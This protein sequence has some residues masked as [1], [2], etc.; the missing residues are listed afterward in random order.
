MWIVA[1]TASLCLNRYLSQE[2]R[3]RFDRFA[4]TVLPDLIALMSNSAKVMATSGIVAIRFI[5][6][7]TYSHRLLPILTSSMTCKSNVT[8][9]CICEFMEIIFQL[10]PVNVLEKHLGLVQDSLRRGICDA[11]SDARVFAR[12]AFPLFA[13]KFPD[14]A[15]VMLQNLDAQKRK[16]VEK[17]MIAAGLAAGA[18]DAESVRSRSNSQTAIQNRVA[19]NPITKRPTKPVLGTTAIVSAAS[20]SRPPVTTLNDYNTVGRYIRQG[21]MAA[22]VDGRGRVPGRKTVSQS[23]PTSRE[24]SPSRLTFMSYGITGDGQQ[25]QQLPYNAAGYATRNGIIDRQ[26]TVDSS[27][28]QGLTSRI[29]R[30]QGASRETSPSRSATG[31]Y[32]TAA[33]PFQHQEHS[34]FNGRGA[35][36]MSY[37]GRTRRE[38]R[39]HFAHR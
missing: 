19:T 13:A 27:Y 8:R 18:G 34:G 6:E 35:N 24:V 7:N 29:P 25:Q 23:Q 32:S 37:R 2:L 20:R 9:K 21:S 38:F 14:Q 15:N 4:E 26:H 5:L 30:S 39:R 31:G 12:R 16:L 10:W 28:H 17:D 1:S 36:F 3:N 33:T 22:T 11:D